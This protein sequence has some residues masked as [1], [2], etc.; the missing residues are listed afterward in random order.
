L[1]CRRH[2]LVWSCESSG[3]GEA[4]KLAHVGLSVNHE[5]YAFDVRVGT[6]SGSTSAFHRVMPAFSDYFGPAARSYASYRPHYPPA[7]FDWVCSVTARRERA[8][9]CG[10]GSGQAA[11]ALAERFA[12]VV[13][14][15]PSVDQLANA[16]AAS[17]LCYVAMTA[18]QTALRAGSVDLVTVA[19]A[20]HWFDRPRF[21]AEVD[22]VLRPGGTLAVWSYGLLAVGPSVDRHVHHLYRDVLGPYWPSERSF[23]DSG[24]AGIALPY[25]ELA[26]PHIAMEAEWSLAEFAGYVSSW[27]AVGRYRA[28][29]GTDPLPAFMHDVAD[30]WG[31]ARRRVRW[32]LAV[33][34]G[35]RPM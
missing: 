3:S 25:A 27:S 23:V 9:D 31:T 20:L 8:W 18:E 14:S 10:T 26:S 6:S 32:P 28:Q 30:A 4:R 29:L 17:G 33:R 13:A 5:V 34:A 15:D 7:L 24:Y 21:F 22:R 1:T 19:Q 16:A 35:R 12:E 11:A 2:T